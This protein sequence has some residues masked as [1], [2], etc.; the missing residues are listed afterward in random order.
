[1]MG[2]VLAIMARAPSAPGKSRLIQDLGTR[3]GEGLRGALLR[4][5]LASVSQLHVEK[6]VLFTPPERETEIRALTPFPA[7]FLAQ[8]GATLGDRMYRGMRDLLGFGF[9]AVVMIGSDLPTLPSVHVGA[10]LDILARR[11]DVLVLGPAE[12][13]GYYLIGVTRPDPQ[14][15]ERIP[16]GTS[17]VLE[18]TCKAAEALGMTVEKISQWYDVDSLSDLRRLRHGVAGAEGI[19]HYTRTWLAAAAFDVRDSCGWCENDQEG[20]T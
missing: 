4:D 16:W 2:P 17:Q 11:P 3:D 18:Y 10:A 14:L 13:G 9:E 12:D 15:F 8:R 6:A 1:M 7:L 19:A 20:L 5:T